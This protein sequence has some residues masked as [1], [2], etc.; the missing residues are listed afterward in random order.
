RV[1]GLLI[2][3]SGIALILLI[4]FVAGAYM[5]A[6]RIPTSFLPDEDQ[7]FF[8]INVQLP[9]AASLQRTDELC[10]KV[11][12]ILSRT[13]GVQNV[14]TTIGSS[15]LSGVQSTYSGFLFVTL[16]PWEDRTQREQQ[17][18]EIK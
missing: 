16:T 18:Q 1:A 12:S 2:R 4:A 7:G 14:T 5:F 13:P 9:D 10:R 3:R 15:L 8:Y 6:K 17:Y 11:E